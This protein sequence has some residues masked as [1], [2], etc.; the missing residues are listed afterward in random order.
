MDN[1]NF[2]DSVKLVVC[3]R[4]SKNAYFEDG[5]GIV[6]RTIAYFEGDGTFILPKCLKA[7]WVGGGTVEC[8]LCVGWAAQLFVVKMLLWEDSRNIILDFSQDATVRIPQSGFHS[9]D[10][11]AKIPQPGS[12]KQVST[13]IIPRQNFPNQVH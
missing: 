8:V 6:W 4:V 12:H 11:T 9:Q 7:F 2:E 5:V 3:V 1:N 10:S 13:A